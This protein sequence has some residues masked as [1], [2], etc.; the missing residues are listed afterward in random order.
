LYDWRGIWARDSQLPPPNWEAVWLILAGR[1]FGKTK[2]GSETVCDLVDAKRA[3]M[4]A[5]V[6]PTSR[7]CVDVMVEGVSGLIASSRP[8][9]KAKFEPSKRRVTWRN[10]AKAIYYSAEE[11][12]RVRGA[13][14][15]FAWGDEPA[16][17]K[18]EDVWDQIQLALRAGDKPLSMVTGTP[19]PVPMI[20]KLVDNPS[21]VVT[22]GS[23]FE[24]AGNLAKN[25]LAKVRELYAG[26]RLG[27]QELEA[28][29][30]RDTPGALFN[31]SSIDA[32][33]KTEPPRELRNIVVAIDPPRSGNEDSD[34]AGIVA[35]GEVD[36]HAYVLEDRSMRGSPLEWA[37]TAVVLYHKYKANR[38][39]AEVNCGGDMVEATVRQVAESIPY[40]PVRATRGKSKRAEPVAALY[41][42]NRVH[43]CGPAEGFDKLERQLHSF[44]GEAG[45]R[46]DRADALCWAITSLLV[47]QEFI[48]FV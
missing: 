45:K 32:N 46:D 37:R 29:L 9:N 34:E 35:V 42:Q 25:F 31:R 13:N 1:G 4:I 6:G 39:V 43:H 24:N 5:L 48:G 47:D 30:L 16:E 7:D 23:T 27:R 28:E 38:V 18:Y 19:K 44:T 22:R 26:T 3:G 2:T 21:T 33:R 12:G 10:G 20:L 40:E 14:L 8:W 41:E 15:D 11:P 17:W 36:G